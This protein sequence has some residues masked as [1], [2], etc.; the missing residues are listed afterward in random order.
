M[1][2]VSLNT[3]RPQLRMRGGRQY[4]TAIDRTP[5][6]GPVALSVGGLDGDRVSDE[7]AHGGPERALCVFASE[8]YAHFEHLLGRALPVPAFGENLTTSGLLEHDVCVGDEYRVGAAR[9]QVTSPRVPCAKLAGKHGEPLMARWVFES[10]CCGFYLRVL[11]TAPLCAG[12]VIERL[13][14]PRAGWTITRLL[15]AFAKTATDEPLWREIA[16][17]PE[18][19][20]SFREFF[21][22]R[23]GGEPAFGE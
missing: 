9:V 5:A 23:L 15:A 16:A 2:I 8:N 3:G 1:H 7:R 21:L 22:R 18:L 17:I 13:A 19:S 14:R 6:Q 20:G 10:G 12:D 4:S 11:D